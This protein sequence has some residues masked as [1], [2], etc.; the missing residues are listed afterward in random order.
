VQHRHGLREVDDMNAVALSE[1]EGRHF[2]VPAMGLVAEVN[3]GLEELAHSEIGQSHESVLFRLASASFSF[4]AEHRIGL[5]R[6]RLP[7]RADPVTKAAVRS[8][9]EWVGVIRS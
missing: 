8:R 4:L 1:D 5:L 9:V 2:R 3:A 6:A 7:L